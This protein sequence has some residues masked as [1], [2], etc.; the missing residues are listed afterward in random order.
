MGARRKCRFGIPVTSLVGGLLPS[1][2]AR[3]WWTPWTILA[4][5]LL[6]PLGGSMRRPP[7]TLSTLF[8]C[9]SVKMGCSSDGVRMNSSRVLVIIIIIIIIIIIVVDTFCF[10]ALLSTMSTACSNAAATVCLVPRLCTLCP[11]TLLGSWSVFFFSAMRN[12][13]FV[14]GKARNVSSSS[15]SLL[16]FFISL[17]FHSAFD[18]AAQS[19]GA[20]V[21]ARMGSRCQHTVAALSCYF[22]I[23]L[24]FFS[25]I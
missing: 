24:F 6:I 1:L 3:L 12:V 16:F 21:H 19:W 13:R 9:L 22:T 5:S 11:R 17:L 23:L 20:T 18:T 25:F 14:N 15:S 7:P 4:R 8:L 10:L 2:F